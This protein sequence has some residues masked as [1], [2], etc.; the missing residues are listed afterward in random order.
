MADRRAVFPIAKETTLSGSSKKRN[1]SFVN[2]KYFYFV[3]F[4]LYKQ[5]SFQS[6]AE[7]MCS[8]NI[9]WIKYTLPIQLIAIFSTKENENFHRSSTKFSIS[10]TIYTLAHERKKNQLKTSAFLSPS[11]RQGII[12]FPLKWKSVFSFQSIKF[13]FLFILFSFQLNAMFKAQIKFKF[14][15]LYSPVTEC[16]NGKAAIF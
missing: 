3:N 8:L 15:N 4:F 2:Y 13:N 1:F 14:G 10:S 12:I 7:K 9:Y 5:I 11:I 6:R 16:G